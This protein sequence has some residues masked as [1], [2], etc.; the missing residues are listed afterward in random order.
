MKF[1]NM[2]YNSLKNCNLL[3]KNIPYQ[4][5]ENEVFQNFIQFGDVKSVKIVK[6]TKEVVDGGKR[7]LVEVPE[8]FGYVCYF[9]PESA[10]DAI[11]KMNGN[12]LKKHENWKYP[13]VVAYWLPKKERM[14]QVNRMKQQLPGFP[15]NPIGMMPNS[16]QGFMRPFMGPMPGY[17]QGGFQGM[18]PMYPQT[19]MQPQITNPYIQRPQFVQQ[20]NQDK[21]NK[22]APQ[23]QVTVQK[24]EELPDMNYLK[25][26]ED[27]ES[28]KDY[29]GEFIFKQIENHEQAQKKNFTIDMIGKITGM[30]L[31]IDDINEI[32][33]I[34]L[35]KT[36]LDHRLKEAMEL[37][38]SG[39]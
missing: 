3:V 18:Q 24:P 8:G 25:S 35:D 17:Q 37:M 5:K 31:G 30:I 16:Q 20:T 39:N 9:N 26:L 1:L 23:Q 13:L 22:F 36:L 10:K 32:A 4:V 12:Y 2:N 33:K 38:D 29:L 28:K 7:T 14:Q 11:E 15:M 19:M 6:K 27:P 21:G 34:A